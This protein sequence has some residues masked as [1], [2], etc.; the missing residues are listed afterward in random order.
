MMTKTL[1]ELG[2]TISQAD[3]QQNTV[4]QYCIAEQPQMLQVSHYLCNA[5]L[6]A[7]VSADEP[8][9]CGSQDNLARLVQ[10]S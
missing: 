1:I 2:A 7:N 10:K 8:T 5:S 3:M 6:N 4:V 9:P